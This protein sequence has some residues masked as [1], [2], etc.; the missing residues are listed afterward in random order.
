MNSSV[1]EFTLDQSSVARSVRW[2]ET[3]SL[4]CKFEFSVV[5]GYKLSR[6]TA[7]N[8][9]PLSSCSHSFFESVSMKRATRHL[10][11]KNTIN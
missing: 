2:L 1:Y 9:V 7:G 10:D 11:A 8:N 3:L 5:T 4:V 6:A